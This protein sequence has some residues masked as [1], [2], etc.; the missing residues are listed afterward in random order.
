MARSR[1]LL[2]TSNNFMR[3]LALIIGAVLVTA[4]TNAQ[5]PII[6]PT[7]TNGLAFS[8][9]NMEIYTAAGYVSGS[10]T[11]VQAKTGV[12][13][14]ISSGF[15]PCVEIANEPTGNVVAEM[16]AFFEYHKIAGSFE[17]IGGIGGRYN[18]DSRK[19]GIMGKVGAN[20]NLT[21]V[22]NT[23]PYLGTQVDLGED[24]RS[25]NRPT[26]TPYIIAGLKF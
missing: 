6:P 25:N 23:F 11:A 19:P 1:S 21:K 9:V 17:L 13:Y 26:V 12:Y 2:F 15:G 24:L 7:A 14:N 22:G 18:W 20:Y 5:V 8:D 16:D 4:V 10:T 3:K